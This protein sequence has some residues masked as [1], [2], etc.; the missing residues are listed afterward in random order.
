M[1]NEYYLIVGTLAAITLLAVHAACA[2]IT[3]S[4]YSSKRKKY[5]FLWGMFLGLFGILA[6]WLIV[7]DRDKKDE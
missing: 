3:Q 6:A 7:R 2:M 5:G 1:N 4:I